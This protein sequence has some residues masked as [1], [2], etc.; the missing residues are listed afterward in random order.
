MGIK[1]MTAGTY[2]LTWFDTVDGDT[3]NP[4]GYFSGQ[5]RRH[6]EQAGFD[7]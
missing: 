7:E 1:N 2:N 3:G 4:D 5:W 6:L